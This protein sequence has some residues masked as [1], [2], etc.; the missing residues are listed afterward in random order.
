MTVKFIMKGMLFFM[1]E[2][3]ISSLR[4]GKKD[5]EKGRREGEG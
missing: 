4:N 2:N 1:G 3:G 5:T